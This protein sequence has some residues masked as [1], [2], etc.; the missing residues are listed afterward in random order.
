[1]IASQ[2]VH[3]Y[4]KFIDLGEDFIGFQNAKDNIAPFQSILADLCL[5]TDSMG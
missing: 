2:E 4:K 5:L 1:M 3:L